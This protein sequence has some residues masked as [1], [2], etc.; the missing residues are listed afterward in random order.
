M[1]KWN[2]FMYQ[3]K[4]ELNNSQH[5]QVSQ[6]KIVCTCLPGENIWFGLQHTLKSCWTGTVITCQSNTLHT[7]ATI[8][9]WIGQTLNDVCFT[10][11]PNE[12]SWAVASK[13]IHFICTCATIKTRVRCTLICVIFTATP[14]KAWSTGAVEVTLNLR[15]L[16]S[17]Y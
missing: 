4:N 9:A 15:S 16:I 11:S 2:K 6:D 7:S 8:F 17:V 5:V 13:T 3:G 12:T 14:F 10:L 1:K